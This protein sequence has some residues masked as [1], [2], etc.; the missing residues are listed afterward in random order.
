MGS[1]RSRIYLILLILV[2]VIWVLI[3][4]QGQHSHS[5]LPV[6]GDI[7]MNGD[8]IPYI[9][10]SFSFTDQNGSVVTEKNF[11]NTIY[12]ANFFFATC[13]DVCPEMNQ[14]MSMVYD[15]FKEYPDVKFISHT[16]HPEHDSVAILKDYSDKL[17]AEAGKWYFVTGKKSEIYNLAENFYRVTA[18]KGSKPADFIH[19]EL[20]VLIDEK[21]QVRGYYESRDFDQIK[22][23]MDGIKVLLKEKRT[24]N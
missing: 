15:K 14:N 5:T 6:Y 9:I 22:K 7:E 21:K 13:P 18:T 24:G 23:L 3:W 17:N 12:V 10:P 8:T 4:K 1:G 16:V 2:P 11:D 19:S 20:L